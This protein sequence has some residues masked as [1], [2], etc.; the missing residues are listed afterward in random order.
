MANG[1]HGRLASRQAVL[2]EQVRN[3]AI[4]RALLSQ[5]RDD[6]LHREQVLEFSRT[7][8]SEFRA[9]LRTAIV[10]NADMGQNSL[11]MNGKTDR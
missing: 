4:R 8:G 1:G 7:A 3:G 6:I 10:S 9:A 11:E 5:L 2:R